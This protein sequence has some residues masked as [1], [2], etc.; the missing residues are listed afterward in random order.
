LYYCIGGA[1][2][3]AIDPYG[4]MNICMLSGM[5]T[6]DMRPG[7]FR[8]GWES[9]LLEKR[10]KKITRKTKCLNCIIKIMCGM[11]PSSGELEN[12]DPE[13]PVDFLCQVA[14]RRAKALGI[15]VKPHGECEYCRTEE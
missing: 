7:S 4:K 15:P 11:C 10:Q 13:E 5:D 3:F 9:F 8:E 14:H 1:A 6:Y 12:R 2:A